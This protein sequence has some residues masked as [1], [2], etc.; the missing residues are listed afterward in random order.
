MQ[1]FAAARFILLLA[2]A[3][4]PLCAAAE[5]PTPSKIKVEFVG[6]DP[7]PP[8]AALCVDDS[9]AKPISEVAR[10]VLRVE[11]GG[12]RG[13][14]TTNLRRDSAE[15]ADRPIQHI[16]IEAGSLDQHNFILAVA[17]CSKR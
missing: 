4:T 12:P 10:W 15:R 6:S 5:D 2:A 1:V 13:R 16:R 9:I 3:F 11:L 17:G 14:A 8:K 7:G